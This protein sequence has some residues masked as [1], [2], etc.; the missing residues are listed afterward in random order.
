LPSLKRRP[1]SLNALATFECAARLSSFGAAAEELNLTR[2]AVSHQI[3][4]LEEVFGVRLFE[5]HRSG[6]ALTPAGARVY[7]RLRKS[8]LDIND[9]TGEFLAKPRRQRL[10]V[11][12]APTFAARWLVGRLDAFL[13]SQPTIDFQLIATSEP[14]DFKDPGL[15]LAISYGMLECP[16]CETAL[17]LNERVQPLCSPSLREKVGLGDVADLARATLIQTDL[18]LISW[19]KWLADHGS[20]LARGTRQIRLNPSYL[21]LEAAAQSVGVVLESDI[22]AHAEI[23]SGRLLAPF[24][25]SYAATNGYFLVRPKDERRRHSDSFC[26]WLIQEAAAFTT[27][28]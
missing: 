13:Q 12:S 27:P 9:I 2:S 7:E 22:L 3:L 5:R 11:Q 19:E 8:L 14:A 10:T 17:L 25:P 16:G 26:E 18:N 15:D 24:D 23:A 20:A 6:V 21:A 1:I 28:A 4:K